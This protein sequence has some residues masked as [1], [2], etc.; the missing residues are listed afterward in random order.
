M[1]VIV[2]NS[3]CVCIWVSWLAS[4]LFLWASKQWEPGLNL[5]IDTYTSMYPTPQIISSP[6][7]HIILT[8]DSVR[9]VRISTVNTYLQRHLF[10]CCRSPITVPIQVER[11]SSKVL[12][13]AASTI[14]Y[15]RMMPRVRPIAAMDRVCNRY[16][17]QGFFVTVS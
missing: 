7:P 15:N 17:K 5:Y 14:Q 3:V 9:I 8:R 4:L 1:Y 10:C 2:L 16:T 12:A 6:W 11:V 13:R